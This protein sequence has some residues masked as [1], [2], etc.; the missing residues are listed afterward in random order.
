MKRTPLNQKIK[1][2]ERNFTEF[3]EDL[4]KTKRYL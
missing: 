4:S 2:V 3:E 1:E